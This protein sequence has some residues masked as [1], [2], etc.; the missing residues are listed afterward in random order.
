MSNDDDSIVPLQFVVLVCLIGRI[1][2]IGTTLFA[3][4]PP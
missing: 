3:M 2:M 1:L 4:Q